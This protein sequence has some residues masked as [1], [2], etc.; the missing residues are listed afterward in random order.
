M[1]ET[2]L[3]QLDAD[4]DEQPFYKPPVEPAAK[5]TDTTPATS[6]SEAATE[7]AARATAEQEA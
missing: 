2:F 6:E 1:W 5:A 7:A 4:D 3:M